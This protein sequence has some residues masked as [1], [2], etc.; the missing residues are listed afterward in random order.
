MSDTKDKITGNDNIILGIDFTDIIDTV[1]G[2]LNFQI[3]SAISII[4]FCLFG[5][6]LF[7][8]VVMIPKGPKGPGGSGLNIPG[9]GQL[10][11]RQPL[12]IQMPMQTTPFPFPNSPF[13]RST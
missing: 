5:S 3:S 13:P 4:L 10:S 8:F 7:A 9:I 1:G 11:P 12:V 2:I 6:I